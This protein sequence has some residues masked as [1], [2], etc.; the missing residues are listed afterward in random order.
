MMSRTD[1]TFTGLKVVDLSSV[2]AGPLTG[3][4][5]AELGAEVV[6]IENKKI[7]GDAT[8]QWKL[9][10]ENAED[11]YS[12]YYF[13]ANFGKKVLLLDLSDLDDKAQ[14]ETLISDADIVISNFQK[15]TAIKLGLEP[16]DLLNRHP[17]LIIAQLSAYEYDDPRP[18]YDLVMQGETGWISMNGTD[19][20][21]LSK[22]PVALV[23]VIAAHQL[24][25]AIL[26]AMFN[27]Y[28]TGKG[29]V[30]HVSLYKS[31]ISALANQASNFLVASQVASPMGTL[32][33]N[34]APYGDVFVTK[35]KKKVIL[36]VGSDRQ[37]EKLWFSLT[38]DTSFYDNFEFNSNRVK[39][40]SQL[41]AYLQALIEPMLYN[42]LEAILKTNNIPFCLIAK[43]DD[44]FNN[45]LAREMINVEMLD[46]YKASSVSNVAFHFQSLT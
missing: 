38:E 45:P 34:I 23:D 25:E 22:L 42:A 37:F 2:L 28:K 16:D 31:A 32:H 3:S 39:N 19:E 21:H 24:K 10:S 41:V 27:K 9:P 36:A 44:V 12:A 15:K 20:D 30:A 18:G 1:T 7:G 43:M 11:P 29:C 4:F 17:H 6:K 14:V 26:I 40:R 8:R 33:P 46:G 35:D 5:F 13:S